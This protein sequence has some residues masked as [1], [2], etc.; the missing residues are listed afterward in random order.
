MGYTRNKPDNI[1]P[2]LIHVPKQMQSCLFL[3]DGIETTVQMRKPRFK[4]A[5]C[6]VV[7]IGLEVEFR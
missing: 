4:D 5:K 2:L 6:F 3:R 1:Y 7:V